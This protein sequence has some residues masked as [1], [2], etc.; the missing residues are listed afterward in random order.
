MAM[1]QACLSTDLILF[2]SK[3]TIVNDKSTA[4]LSIYT[5]LVL[6]L[7]PGCHS[8]QQPMQVIILW[9]QG[10][11]AT[12]SPSLHGNKSSGIYKKGCLGK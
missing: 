10:T 2:L 7:L 8:M 3:N 9:L 12:L 6:V 5:Y 11:L 1:M 4:C